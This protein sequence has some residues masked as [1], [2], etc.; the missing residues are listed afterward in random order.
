[1][2][3]LNAVIHKMYDQAIEQSKQLPEGPFKGVPMLIKDISQEIKGEPMTSGSKALQN[4]RATEDSNYVKKLRQ[5]GVTFLGIT[6]VPEFALM[7]VTEPAHY[8]PTRNPWNTEYTP[9]G[10]SGGSAS[11]VA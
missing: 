1:N 8:G 7:G 10:S 2:P 3:T 4:N 6:N 5:A 9:G 11:A